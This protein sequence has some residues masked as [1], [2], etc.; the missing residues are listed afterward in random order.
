[1]EWTVRL[2]TITSQSLYKKFDPSGLTDD[3]RAQHDE[4]SNGLQTGC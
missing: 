2:V 4:R 1:M 3:D